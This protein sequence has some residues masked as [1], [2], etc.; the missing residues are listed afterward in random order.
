MCDEFK[1]IIALLLLQIISCFE[2]LFEN[3]ISYEKVSS[4]K[5]IIIIIFRAIHGTFAHG[6]GGLTRLQEVQYAA[7]SIYVVG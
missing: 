4:I 6:I 1:H 3:H 7:I 2:V 5:M